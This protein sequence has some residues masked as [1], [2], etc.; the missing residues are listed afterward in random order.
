MSRGLWLEVL[1]AEADREWEGVVVEA[2]REVRDE[3]RRGVVGREGSSRPVLRVREV[4]RVRYECGG[5]EVG[6]V[7]SMI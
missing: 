2:R 1:P 7:D 4:E 6:V 5:A 3:A